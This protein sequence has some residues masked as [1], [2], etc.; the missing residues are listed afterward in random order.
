MSFLENLRAKKAAAAAQENKGAF[1]AT[2]EEAP[3][4]SP[5]AMLAALREKRKAKQETKPAEDNVEQ[6]QEKEE[7]DLQAKVDAVVEKIKDEPVKAPEN[8]APAEEKQEAEASPEEDSADTTEEPT[9]DEKAPEETPEEMPEE[10]P[11]RK[12]GRKSKKEAEPEKP[13]TGENGDVKVSQFVNN[14]DILGKKFNYDEIAG[15]TLDYFEDDGWKET[16]KTLSEKMAAIRIESDMN[17]GTLKYALA[18]LNN[19]YD[20]ANIVYMDQKKLMDAL[21]DKDFG[22]AV[23]YQAVNS[24]GSNT[25]ERKRN[26][27]LALTHAKVGDHEVN[28]IAMI[29]AIK[30]RYAFISDFL[31]RIR[32]KSDLCITMS[33]AIKMEQSMTL[34]A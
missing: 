14:Y 7:E 12:R 3:K 31:K 30:V 25:E 16:E 33:G 17:P 27:F 18:A 8:D 29:A 32:Y 5:S 26:G 24:Y 28:Y 23:A 21:C 34:G 15:I 4:K 2:R 10:A 13:A 11:K 20:E 1:E 19:L 22:A 6:Q 9:K